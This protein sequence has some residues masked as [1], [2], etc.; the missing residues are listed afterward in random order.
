MSKESR[1]RAA[2]AVQTALYSPETI[3]RKMLEAI[4]EDPTRDGL[5]DTPKR[6]VKSWGELFSGYH[7]SPKKILERA[8]ESDGYDQLIALT[9]I[10]F[11]TFCEH[12]LL[13]FYGVAH[14]AYIPRKGGKVVGLSKL[15]R[16]V[17]CFARRLQI[18]ERLTQQI[19]EALLLNLNP[20]AVG[21]VIESRHTCMVARGV[22]RRSAL[23][24]TSFLKGSLKEDQAAR[25]EFFSLIRGGRSVEPR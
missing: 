4:G 10:E 8:F 1:A 25:E 23:M 17:D 21:V 6:V 5:R 24:S 3:V 18:Q 9:D 13:P 12:H 15:A 19:G 7:Q 14:V 11:F 22:Q 16:L 2:Q 20:K